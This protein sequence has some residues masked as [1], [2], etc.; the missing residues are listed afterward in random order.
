MIITSH[1][2]RYPLQ[3]IVCLGQIY[4]DILYYATSLF[5]YYHK[6]LNYCRP[7][8]YYFWFYFFFMNFI[9]IVIPGR[10]YKDLLR[11]STLTGHSTFGG[12]CQDYRKGLQGIGPN[13]ALSTSKRRCKEAQGKW[14]HKTRIESVQNQGSLHVAHRHQV[15]DYGLCKEDGRP[16]ISTP[17]SPKMG[18][19]H[20]CICTYHHC[21]LLPVAVLVC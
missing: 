15:V 10:K 4:G 19:T 5:D 9:W 1:P 18:V 8:A 7:E 21:L 14:S 3:G 13:V 2:L 17:H 6:Q 20:R 11:L 16:A 12:Q